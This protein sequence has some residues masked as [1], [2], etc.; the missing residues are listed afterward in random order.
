M[1]KR[2]KTKSNVREKKIK[3]TTILTG[4]TTRL[5]ETVERF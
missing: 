3:K 2:V 5:E 1:K 4:A